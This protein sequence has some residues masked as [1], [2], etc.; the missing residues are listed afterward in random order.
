MYMRERGRERDIVYH[1][2]ISMGGGAN[3]CGL[4]AHLAQPEEDCMVLH[5]LSAPIFKLA[6]HFLGEKQKRPS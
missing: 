2:C 1:S 5:T 4:T 3:S 6:L